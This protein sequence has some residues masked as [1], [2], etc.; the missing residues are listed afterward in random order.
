[1]LS[2]NGPFLNKNTYAKGF[3][4][5][6]SLKIQLKKISNFNFLINSLKEKV[7]YQ[8]FQIKRN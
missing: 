4:L 6:F 7:S 8:P 5:F 2:I 1:M 3:K